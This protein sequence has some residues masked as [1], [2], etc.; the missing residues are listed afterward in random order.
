MVFFTAF[1]PISTHSLS[2]KASKGDGPENK[3]SRVSEGRSLSA[4]IVQLS[5]GN[6]DYSTKKL[7][8]DAEQC[9]INQSINQS[10]L[11]LFRFVPNL[12]Y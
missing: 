6:D 5:A 7:F 1:L 8:Q 12:H 9:V 3:R 2:H 11:L 10:N 4:K